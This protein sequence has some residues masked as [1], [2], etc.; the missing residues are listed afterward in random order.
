MVEAGMKPARTLGP[1]LVVAV[2]LGV[3]AA[4]AAAHSVKVSPKVGDAATK[5]VFKGKKWQPG[6]DVLASTTRP[7]T[8]TS[9]SGRSCS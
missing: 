3:F 9:R 1:A 5:F 6:G 8:P 7:R 4:P 2:L